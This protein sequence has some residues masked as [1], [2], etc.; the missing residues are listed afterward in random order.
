VNADT[1]IGVSYQVSGIRTGS[2]ISFERE[3]GTAK[4]WKAVARYK[5]QGSTSESVNLPGDAIGKYL[6]RLRV[7]NGRKVV[8]QSTPHP[9]YSYGSISYLT[10]CNQATGGSPNCGTNTVQLQ[11]STLYN[12]ESITDTYLSAPPGTSSLAFPNTSCRSGSL[13]IETGYTWE[14]NPGEVTSVQITQSASDPQIATLPDTSQ[15]VF[16][17]KLDGGPFD[18][19]EWYLGGIENPVAV[20]YSGTLNCYTLNGLR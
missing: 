6:Y 17:F 1:P 4:V 5:F 13:T 19:D 7:T 12:Y 11:N 3:F 20:Y 18:L 14:T 8:F 15:I 16:N 10:I 2:L 9:L